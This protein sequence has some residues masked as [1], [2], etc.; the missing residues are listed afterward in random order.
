MEM[1]SALMDLCEGKLSV[2]GGFLS[3]GLIMQIFDFLLLLHRTNFEMQNHVAGK[4]H[5]ANITHQIFFLILTETQ[6]V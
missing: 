1:F 3:H 6:N 4:R 2:A 5:I